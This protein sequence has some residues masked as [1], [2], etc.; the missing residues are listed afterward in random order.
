MSTQKD[1]RARARKGVAT[2]AF[3]PFQEGVRSGRI[4]LTLGVF[5]VD[6]PNAPEAAPEAFPATVG[7][8]VYGYGL[9]G[10]PGRRVARCPRSG[11]AYASPTAETARL[12]V[13]IEEGRRVPPALTASRAHSMLSPLAKNRAV[14][15]FARGRFPR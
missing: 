1:S 6:A 5:A 14:G 4:R 9:E 10:V 12:T 13:V 11:F 3:C 2:V 7:R 15:W 8:S